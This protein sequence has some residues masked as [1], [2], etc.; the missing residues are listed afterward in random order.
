VL[1]FGWTWRGE[2]VAW[3]REHQGGRIEPE[4]EDVK[5]PVGI[6]IGDNPTAGEAV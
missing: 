1:T 5:V 4:A 2:T 3:N 6:G